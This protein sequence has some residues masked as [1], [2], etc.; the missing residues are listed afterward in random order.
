MN[1][2][3]LLLVG[4]VR[5]FGNDPLPIV[6]GSLLIVKIDRDE[7]FFNRQQINFSR[8]SH[9]LVEIIFD[10]SGVSDERNFAFITAGIFDG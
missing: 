3:F 9:H 2:N 1:Q 4:L 6:L 7:H 5:H 10:R 8:S